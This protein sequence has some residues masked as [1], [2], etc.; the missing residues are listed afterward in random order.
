MQAL[1]MAATCYLWPYFYV[2]SFSH[3]TL[4]RQMKS[5]WRTRGKGHVTDV[6]E[7]FQ[8]PVL[9]GARRSSN[10]WAAY[11]GFYQMNL[12]AIPTRVG[13]CPAPRTFYTIR[14]TSQ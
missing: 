5:A 9:P 2:A 3:D 13:M 11:Y 12:K 7:P 14:P 8:G 4:R 10:S 6:V 1:L